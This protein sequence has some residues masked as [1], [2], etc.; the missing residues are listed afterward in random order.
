M[1][2]A[3]YFIAG[4]LG[5]ALM[6]CADDGPDAPPDDPNIPLDE[7]CQEIAAADCARLS[8]C[9]TLPAPFDLV[10]C[11]VQQEAS[12]CSPVQAA[13]QNA[14]SAGSLD[15]F[16]LAARDCRAAIAA[17][18]CEVGMRHDLLAPAACRA[19]VSAQGEQGDACH[20]GFD[21]ADGFYCDNGAACPGRC[22]PLKSNNQ[23]CTF[24]ERCEDA[25]YCDVTA[26]RCLAR[27]DLGGTCGLAL[28]GSSCVD[29]TFC[30]QSNPATPV[31]ARARGRNEGC[32]SDAEC[33]SGGLCLA[34]RCSTGQESDAC[35]EGYHCD[36]DLVC[37]SGACRGF[38]I[39]DDACTPSGVPC[40][41]GLTCT[42]TQ[43]ATRCR[44]D[45]PLG[46]VCGADTGCLLGRCV[47][48]RCAEAVPD[49]GVCT[50]ADACL[51]NRSCEAGRCVV[52]PRDC[53]YPVAN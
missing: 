28:S 32:N 10:T 43:G 1:G 5:T 42:S 4:L 21:C 22:A 53:R 20:L 19:M 47:D 13:L 17:L 39:L 6:A 30:D 33:A 23:P 14:V 49:G 27:T 2:L 44:P 52:V 25:L 11:P 34:N 48:G 41:A 24:G 18:P 8:A 37:V 45:A 15:Y 40:A 12:L 26:M 46:A 36:P 50:D 9:G 7:L 29:G 35:V 51:P 16:E 3:K 38:G 31:C